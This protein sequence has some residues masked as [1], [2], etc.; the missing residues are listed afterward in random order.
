MS[1]EPLYIDLLITD[2]NF[3]LDSGNEPRRCNNRDSIAQDII[4]SI[5]ESGITARL[6]GERSP[7]MRGDVITR[8]TLLVE[9]D[10]RL[11]PGTIVITEESISRLYVTAETYDFGSVNTE[12][13][14]D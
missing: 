8:L 11:I 7:T 4:H 13:N 9:S 5:L 12:V 3:T 10:E 6:I 14:Y 1:T 2:G